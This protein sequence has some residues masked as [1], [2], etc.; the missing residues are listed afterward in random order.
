M[1]WIRLRVGQM[2]MPPATTSTS[3]PRSLVEV[4][5]VAQRPSD[6]DRVALAELGDRVGHATDRAHDQIEGVGPRRRAGEA[7][8]D[9]AVPEEGELGDLAGRVLHGPAVVHREREVRL[10]RGRLQGVDDGRLAGQEDVLDF[11]PVAL[12]AA[13]LSHLTRP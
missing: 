5:A 9:L 2:P 7:D 10:G 8:G 12:M 6:V 13:H 4:E 3:R 1:Y 11:G